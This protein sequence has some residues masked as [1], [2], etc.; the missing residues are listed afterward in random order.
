MNSLSITSDTLLKNEMINNYQSKFG[1]NK[2]NFLINCAHLHLL[3]T[4][5]G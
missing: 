1:V 5:D 2:V 3:C 4:E